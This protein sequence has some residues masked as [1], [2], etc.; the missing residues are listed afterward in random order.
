ML[1]RKSAPY[2]NV[3]DFSNSDVVLIKDLLFLSL[4]PST[5]TKMYLHILESALCLKG[6][7][8]LDFTPPPLC[9]QKTNP[10]WPLIDMLNRL[11]ILIRFSFVLMLYQ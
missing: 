4:I 9:S 1:I 6:T 5:A 11:Q 8:S 7:E 10:S 3:Y 2:K